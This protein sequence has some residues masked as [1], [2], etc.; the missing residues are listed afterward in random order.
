M[1]TH[2]NRRRRL[3]L[4]ALLGLGVVAG[5]GLVTTSAAWTDDAVFTVQASA[6][7][8]DLRGSADGS[9]Y[10]TADDVGTAVRL[11]PIVDLT[12]DEPAVRTVHLWNAGSVPVNLTWS[13]TN[14]TSLLDGCVDVTYS[15]LEPALQPGQTPVGAAVTT[16]TVTFTVADDADAATCSGR[17]VSDVIV[18][19]QGST[20]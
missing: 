12:P 18:V 6:G 19:V 7:H 15:T 4:P 5:F 11:D 17:S 3:A 13:S 16:A 2:P 20:S 1:T 9:T 14:P 8:V 10:T